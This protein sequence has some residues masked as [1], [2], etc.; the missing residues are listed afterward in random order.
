MVS[1]L[2]SSAVALACGVCVAS[3]MWHSKAH[4]APGRHAQAPA[5]EMAPPAIE[6]SGRIANVEARA[7]ANANAHADADANANAHANAYPHATATATS[8]PTVTSTPSARSSTIL[9]RDA[10]NTLRAGQ[11]E[12]KCTWRSLDQGN[13]GA[14]VQVCE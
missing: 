8:T 3:A 12:L 1:L 4:A 13:A 7:D 5:V 11:H 14:R 9:M 10:Q 2:F 6:F